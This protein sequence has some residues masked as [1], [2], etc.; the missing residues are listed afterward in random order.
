MSDVVRPLVLGIRRDE[1]LG[2]HQELSA[3]VPTVL[4]RRPED[5]EPDFL[6]QLNP[7]WLVFVDWS[8]IVPESILDEFPCV[9]FHAA[10][11]P[12]YRGGSPLQHQ[13]ID[14]LRET[15]LCLIRL[16]SEVDG[17]SILVQRALDLRGTISEVWARLAGLVP[18][19]INDLLTEAYAERVQ[20]E[21]GFIRRRRR[22]SE[23]ELPNLSAPLERLYDFVRAL[24]DPYP[25]AFLRLDDKRVALRSPRMEGDALIAEVV[26]TQGEATSD[27]E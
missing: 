15:K 2:I 27:P 26:I 6:R 4:V 12:R 10:D 16:V 23:S 7:S 25:N 8:W 5:V 14:G 19:M 9:G 13:I 20:P 1:N 22:P 11:L 18:G 3:R 17:G 24:D 21:G